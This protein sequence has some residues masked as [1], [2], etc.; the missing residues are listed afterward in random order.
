M[1]A[2]ARLAGE[3]T[4]CLRFRAEEVGHG[5]AA[6]RYLTLHAT[7]SRGPRAEAAAEGYVAPRPI[8]DFAIAA[9]VMAAP[10]LGAMG[11]AAVSRCR[12]YAARPASR[13]SRNGM[14]TRGAR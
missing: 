4:A 1:I 2:G 7:L 12:A 9:A 5:L 11:A 8:D 3:D 14:L 10:T 13:R 6:R